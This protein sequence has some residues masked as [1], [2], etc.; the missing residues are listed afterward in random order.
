[1][2][3]RAA[4]I[5]NIKLNFETQWKMPKG[6]AAAAAATAGRAIKQFSVN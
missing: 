2:L 1:M 4:T 5:K 3:K 6:K